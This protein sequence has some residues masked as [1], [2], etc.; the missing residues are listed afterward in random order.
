[1]RRKVSK[2]KNSK[3]F[4]GAAALANHLFN[5]LNK[6]GYSLQK[7]IVFFNLEKIGL[8]IK[9][10]FYKLEIINRS[11]LPFKQEPFYNSGLMIFFIIFY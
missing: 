6:F 9:K 4:S 11:F 7:R 8:K 5:I 1:M 2:I 3:D 10:D